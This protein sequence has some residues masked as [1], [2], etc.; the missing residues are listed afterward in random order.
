MDSA[1]EPKLV[2]P[3]KDKFSNKDTEL[4]CN[5]LDSEHNE[6]NYDFH[7]RC[8]NLRLLELATVVEE[9]EIQVVFCA[10]VSLDQGVKHPELMMQ[11]STANEPCVCT[12]IY[13]S[14]HSCGRV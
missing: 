4:L 9:V 11:T 5:S 10:I 12:T 6:K 1:A 3:Q 13:L 14:S 8:V 2:K 7:Q